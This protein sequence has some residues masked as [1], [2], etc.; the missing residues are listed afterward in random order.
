MVCSGD[1][2]N[3]ELLILQH[4]E[5]LEERRDRSLLIQGSRM[6]V[7]IV[8]LLHHFFLF[9][10]PEHGKYNREFHVA[11]LLLVQ[12]NHFPNKVFACVSCIS[13]PQALVI[14]LHIHPIARKEIKL[15]M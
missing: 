11:S 13:S 8:S 14:K 5:A 12:I 9:S 7:K 4:L 1:G 15:T 6:V 2:N 10:A 3:I